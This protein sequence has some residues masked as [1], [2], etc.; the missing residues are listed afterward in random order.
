[1]KNITL[2]LLFFISMAFAQRV[3]PT[4]NWSNKADYQ[5]NGETAVTFKPG[6]NIT[7]EITYTLGA[8]NGTNDAFN[9]MLAG[10]QDE[11]IANHDV[12]N[13]TWANETV[14]QPNDY[15]YPGAGTGGVTTVSYTIPADAQLSSENANL[16]YRLLT[17]LAY[18]PDGGATIYGGPGA[19]DPT[20][21]YIRSQAEINALSTSGFNKNKLK[22]YYNANTE[23]IVFKDA[24]I[25]GD[26]AV[27]NLM[28]QEVLR[29]AV[30]KVIAVSTLKP[31]LY[32]LSTAG[33]SLKF[34]K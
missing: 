29:G 1:M 32:I 23:A 22:A 26:Y 8:T 34:V 33:G 28:G 14:A 9:F 30:S 5:I 15:V 11:P 18:T 25:A 21:V 17:Y 13:G 16:T 27:Y 3:E 19:S 20:L 24:T 10:L 4:F 6:D 31:G 2:L 12:I 7:V